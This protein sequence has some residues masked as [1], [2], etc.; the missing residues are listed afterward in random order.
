[1]ARLSPHNFT[2]TQGEYEMKLRGIQIEDKCKKC[3]STNLHR[4]QSMHGS[5]N[6]N[7]CGFSEKIKWENFLRYRT[8]EQFLS[9][10]GPD[11]TVN[12]PCCD[13]YEEAKECMFKSRIGDTFIFIRKPDCHLSSIEI[14]GSSCTFHADR[15]T[16]K[17]IQENK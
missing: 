15:W 11:Y 4:D 13:C 16:R 9:E 1:M 14:N 6:C 8:L 7:D 17:F 10:L 5:I 12:I 2:H 3:G